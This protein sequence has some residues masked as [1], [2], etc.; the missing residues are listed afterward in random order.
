MFAGYSASPPDADAWWNIEGGYT[1]VEP[2]MADGID[3]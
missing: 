2:D 3:R 1:Q